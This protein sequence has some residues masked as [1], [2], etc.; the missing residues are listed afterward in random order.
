MKKHKHYHMQL[1]TDK[2]DQSLNC[3][4]NT[5]LYYAKFRTGMH[6]VSNGEDLQ[7]HLLLPNMCA[8]YFQFNDL[9]GEFNTIYRRVYS[10]AS[11]WSVT[12]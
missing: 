1:F 6:E 5:N 7:N 12:T 9:Q 4:D 8:I 11:L 10:V 3:T 2:L